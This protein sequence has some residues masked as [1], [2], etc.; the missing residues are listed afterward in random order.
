MRLITYCKHCHS[1]AEYYKKL[2]PNIILA[3]VIKRDMDGNT[4]Y[5]YLIAIDSNASTIIDVFEYENDKLRYLLTMDKFTI[6]ILGQTLGSDRF[7]ET[8]NG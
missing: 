7:K 6:Y 4:I 8:V 1:I 2:D 5:L 3:K